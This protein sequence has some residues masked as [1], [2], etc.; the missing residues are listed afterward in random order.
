M[1]TEAKLGDVDVNI[2]DLD[3]PFLQERFEVNAPGDNDHNLVRRGNKMFWAVYNAGTRVI[4]MQHKKDGLHLEEIARLDSEPR[5]PPAFNG[6]WGI[7]PFE[8][9][10][11]VVASDIVNGLMVMRLGNEDDGGDGPRIASAGAAVP[12]TFAATAAR[13]PRS[14]TINKVELLDLLH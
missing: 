6:Q 9:S 8:S 1:I 5:M 14:A 3:N 10:D 12:A 13:A 4:K 11:T 2:Q 7:F